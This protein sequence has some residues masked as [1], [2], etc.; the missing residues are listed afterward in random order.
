MHIKSSEQCTLERE[1][2][3]SSFKGMLACAT[4]HATVLKSGTAGYSA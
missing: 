4:L 2:L 3:E 1:F